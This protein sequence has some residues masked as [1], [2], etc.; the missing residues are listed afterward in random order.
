MLRRNVSFCY[1]W[2]R[3]LVTK[4]ES[5]FTVDCF[6]TPGV[7][8]TWLISGT[9]RK[10]FIGLV[11]N[12]FLFKFTYAHKKK[13]EKTGENFET[14]CLAR[15]IGSRLS[16]HKRP[17]N[18]WKSGG[19]NQLNVSESLLSAGSLMTKIFNSMLDIKIVTHQL[20]CQ[21][22]LP[23]MI[24]NDAEYIDFERSKMRI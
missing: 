4:I 21:I 19:D 15:Y 11:G 10:R 8:W 2:L 22:K 7:E 13:I 12:E 20:P 17:R 14:A 24:E 16:P 6:I 1:Y 23:V 18:M 5:G 3:C 9:D